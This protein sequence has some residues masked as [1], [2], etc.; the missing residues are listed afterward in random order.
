MAAALERAAPDAI[1]HVGV[2]GA[3][4]ASGV[5][6]LEVVVGSEAVYEDLVTARKLAPTLVSADQRLVEAASAA[7]PSARVMPIGTTG[8]V[9]G[10]SGCQVEAMEGFAVLRAA[11]L[12]RRAGGRGAR[13]L[14]P[15][16]GRAQRVAA[17]GRARRARRRTRAARRGAVAAAQGRRAGWIRG[18]RRF[19][20]PLRP[21]SLAGAGQASNVSR[22]WP[23]TRAHETRG[24][25]RCLR[26]HGRSGSSWRRPSGSTAG[27]SS[28]R[29]RS[30]CHWRCST[31]RT[32]RAS[33]LPRPP[34]R[35]G[36]RS[37][38]TC[39]TSS[40]ST[41]RCA[42]ALAGLRSCRRARRAERAPVDPG[43][44]DR[45]RGGDD[46]VLAGRTRCCPRSSSSVWR[47]SPSSGSSCRSV[48]WS[49]RGSCTGLR[50]ALALGRVD[51]VHAFG[52]LATFA[53][54][55]WLTR[56]ALVLLLREQ[57]DNTIRTAA[58]LGDLVL[59]PLLF[60]GPALLYADQA[61]R[62]RVRSK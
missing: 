24:R 43:L 36:G 20:D 52:A 2:A 41:R 13:D 3:R 56:T 15:R 38:A 60:L 47:G 27:G 51:Y 4:R 25:L 8:R 44:G 50:R 18:D 6:V 62:L 46:R 7:L 11:E 29:S 32:S 10:A 35:R 48:S 59:S 26:R 37:R 39:G 49:A 28:R 19:A 5:E 40:C 17:G 54:V 30:A 1:L 9:G 14:E 22:R 57:A 33:I 42:S 21:Q 16:R 53:L 58:F 23:A 34:T 61:A 55:Y 12:R 45:G 31:R